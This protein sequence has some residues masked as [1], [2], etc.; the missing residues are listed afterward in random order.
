MSEHGTLAELIA[1]PDNLRKHN[2]RNVGMIEEG[3]REVGAARSIVVDEN[4]VVLA[5]NGVVEA[6]A[7][8][9][10]TRVRYV[11]ADG[12]EIIAV[13]RRNLTDEQKKRLAIYDNR[14]SE[15]SEWDA[16]SLREL[17]E[18][19]PDLLEGLWYDEEL[20]RDL[21]RM[22]RVADPFSPSEEPTS[23]SHVF[24]DEEVAAARDK[25]TSAF[26]GEETYKPVTCPECGHEFYVSP[27]DVPDDA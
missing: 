15:L 12:E 14:T 7:S 8:A 24:S 18:S 23:S 21:A 26:S 16:V 9:G 6:A 10:I 20:E 22:E 19:D 1:D 27:K 3:L 25:L 2:P 11:D 4:G 17:Q 13:R 5:G